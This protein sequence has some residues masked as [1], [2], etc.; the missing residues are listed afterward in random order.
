MMRSTEKTF[1]M[2]TL[3]F[4]ALLCNG[5]SYIMFWEDPDVVEG[6][7]SADDKA[8]AYED[9][10]KSD[11]T[12]AEM[13]KKLA[14]L[15]SRFDQMEE[16][17]FAQKQKIHVLEKGLKLG[18]MPEESDVRKVAVELPEQAKP[19]AAKKIVSTEMTDA[20]KQQFQNMLA[21]AHDY[22]R[23]GR[24]G[25]AIKQFSSID[26]NFGPKIKDG[27]HH[28]WIAKSW[29]YLKEFNIATQRYSEFLSEYPGSAWAGRAKL[30]L[31]RIQL[32]QGMRETAIDGFKRIIS[33]YPYEEV[34]EMAK[35]ELQNLEK[36]F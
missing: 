33:D 16:Q 19:N 22:F 4:V 11:L 28:Y 34:A 12:M 24:Y 5:C 21:S 30:D 20:E 27:M 9:V 2:F 13:E 1:K 10:E 23:T 15:W 7:K 17:V 32:R 29:M 25:R 6:E 18:I 35:M 3:I 14:R 31:S 36:T 26:E 8:P